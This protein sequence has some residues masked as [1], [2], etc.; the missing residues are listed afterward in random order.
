VKLDATDSGPDGPVFDFDPFTNSQVGFNGY[1]IG[2]PVAKGQYVDVPVAVHYCLECAKQ[3]PWPAT[4]RPSPWP[5]GGGAVVVVVAKNARGGS[6]IHD[7]LY[8]GSSL[9]DYLAKLLKKPAP[10]AS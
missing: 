8:D 9:H 10:R 2:A 1:A 6:V 7:I 4:F 5:S 3:T